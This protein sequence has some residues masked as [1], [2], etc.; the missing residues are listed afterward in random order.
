MPATIL[1]LNP[2]GNSLKA[3]FV[4]CRAS[5][6]Y[7][8]EGRTLL[9]V[10]IEGIGKASEISILKGKEKTSTEA[11]SA[12]S[13][14]QAASSFLK[15]CDNRS[16]SGE[17][18]ELS[19]VGA[20][21]IRVVHGGRDFVEPA[22]MDQHVIDRITQ[23]EKLSPLHNQSSI[24]VLAPVCCQFPGVPVYAVFD[25][26]FHHTMP[27]HASLY[28]IPPDLA[29][30]H[31][32][33]RYGFHGISHRYLLERY[34]HLAGKVPEECSIVSTHLESGCSLTAI[35]KGRSVD[36]T[37]GLT[38]LEG[39]MMGTRSG[40]IDPSIVALLMREEHMAVDDVM[41]LLNRKSGLLGVSGDSLDTRILMKEYESNPRAKLAMDMFAYRVRK[42]AGSFVA[43]LGSVDAIVFGGGIAENGP[44]LRRVVCEGLSGFGLKLDHKANE[45]LIDQEGLLSTSGSPLKAWVIPTQEGLQMAH[46]CVRKMSMKDQ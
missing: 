39:M 22:L 40:D 2:G 19:D 37:M 25:T 16:H 24:E 46:E 10:S 15:W 14:E 7:A 13:Y 35:E 44:F 3:E 36:N 6:Q 9:S 1:T 21:A 31:Q 38:P 4:E 26:A 8:F 32:I 12:G 45:E 43:A 23:F 18:A 34:A 11:I 41:T 42:A 17:H 29:E 27:D 20:V 5:Q 33:R 30:R 28:A